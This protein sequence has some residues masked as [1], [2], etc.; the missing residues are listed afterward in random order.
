MLGPTY[1][2][3]NSLSSVSILRWGRFFFFSKTLFLSRLLMEHRPKIEPRLG[4]NDHMNLDDMSIQQLVSLLRTA[5]RTEQVDE[6]KIVFSEEIEASRWIIIRYENSACRWYE[7]FEGSFENHP[8]VPGHHHY[9]EMTNVPNRSCHKRKQLL[10]VFVMKLILICSDVLKV[11]WFIFG[12]MY[13]KV[14]QTVY[15]KLIN[16]SWE[17]ESLKMKN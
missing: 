7:I 14:N 17:D 10:F 4:S 2:H 1:Y 5:L 9:S 16:H 12:Y 13:V 8:S 15:F 11:K 3:F 6:V